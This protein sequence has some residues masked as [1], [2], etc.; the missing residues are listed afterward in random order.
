MREVESEFKRLEIEPTPGSLRWSRS[1]RCQLDVEGGVIVRGPSAPLSLRS[2]LL[3]LF[4]I[5]TSRLLRNLD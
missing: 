5:G 3:S 4:G 2:G 1:R